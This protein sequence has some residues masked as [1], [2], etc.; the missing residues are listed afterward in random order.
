V[1]KTTRFVVPKGGVLELA[2]GGGGYGA[3]ANRA[4]AAVLRDLE[5]GYIS[6]AFAAQHYP[7]VTLPSSG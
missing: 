1:P 3:P 6:R 2:T 7:H 4:P 5:A